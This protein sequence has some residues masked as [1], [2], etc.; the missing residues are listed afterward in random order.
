MEKIRTLIAD[1]ELIIRRGLQKMLEKDPAIE[2]VGEAEDGELALMLCL[3]KKPDLAFVDIN[4]PFL[5][6]LSFIERLRQN[7]PSTLVIVISG[8]DDF[9]YAR[10]AIQ[11]GVFA[12]LLKPVR[13][14][15]F[16]ETLNKAKHALIKSMETEQYLVWAKEQLAK[17]KEALLSHFLQALLAGSYEQ[18]EILMEMKYLNSSIPDPFS[19]FLCKIQQ[20]PSLV[21]EGAWQDSLVFFAAREQALSLF[22]PETLCYRQG[23]NEVVFLCKAV[24]HEEEKRLLDSLK[25]RIER[26]LP[27]EVISLSARGEGYLSIAEKFASLEEELAT[28]TQLPKTM[29]QAV[30]YLG[31]HYWQ[32]S[33]SLR[34]VSDHVQVTTQ[35]LSRLF[36]SALNVT[37]VEY[38]TILRVQKAVEL[39]KDSE[40]KIYE[41]A[42]EVGYSSQHYFCTAFKRVLHLSPQ[43]YRKTQYKG[44]N[45]A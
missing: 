44:E 11:L 23:S 1:D 17:N 41:V 12:Y 9:E 25:E 13:E 33:I 2:L 30:D 3:E 32:N 6:G 16:F 31:K 45:N 28:I 42:E 14:N 5:D 38:L 29:V 36:K 19:L 8:Y 24:S 4:M 26:H 40:K 20:K 27:A 21:D 15:L 7:S 34:E 39:M 18:E 35:H 37:F 22:P 10:K 43:E